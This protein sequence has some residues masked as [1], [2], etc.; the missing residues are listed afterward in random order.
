MSAVTVKNPETL[1]QAA[2]ELWCARCG[3]GV[4]VRREPPACPM[5]RAMHWRERAPWARQN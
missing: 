3:Y 1:L 4:V 5:C 2:R